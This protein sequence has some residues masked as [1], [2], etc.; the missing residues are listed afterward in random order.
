MGQPRSC[1]DTSLTNAI[2]QTILQDAYRLHE[3]AAPCCQGLAT[4]WPAISQ[5][6][7]PC[8]VG[9]VLWLHHMCRKIDGRLLPCILVLCVLQGDSPM[10]KPLLHC[11]PNPHSAPSASGRQALPAALLSISSCRHS[12]S[13]PEQATAAVRQSGKLS[14]SAVCTYTCRL[15]GSWLEQALNARA[16]GQIKSHLLPQ[17]FL[18]NNNALA[19]ICKLCCLPALT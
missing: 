15:G 14:A 6:Q 3:T 19:I 18:E 11:L 16:E 13:I 12:G 2:W 9:V 7:L 5:P 8:C 4:P 17:Q 10:Q 1:S